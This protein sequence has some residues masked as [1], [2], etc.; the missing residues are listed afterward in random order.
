MEPD[1]WSTACIYLGFYFQTSAGFGISYVYICAIISRLLQALGYHMYIC[2]LLFQ[3]SAGPGVPHVYTCAIILSPTHLPSPS[4]F[5]RHLLP[6]ILLDYPGYLLS[7][8][9]Y[10]LRWHQLPHRMAFSVRRPTGQLP[11]SEG[12]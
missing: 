3:T 1:F 8:T 6:Y 11:G 10:Q 2:V 4:L 7:L 12:F 5:L 9:S